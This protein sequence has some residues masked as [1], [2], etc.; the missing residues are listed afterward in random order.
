MKEFEIKVRCATKSINSLLHS[1]YYYVRNDRK[2][3]N[4]VVEFSHTTERCKCSPAWL[5]A[6]KMIEKQGTETKLILFMVMSQ[7][8]KVLFLFE[9]N[10]RLLMQIV[11][12]KEDSL[13]KSKSQPQ[14]YCGL[15]HLKVIIICIS[16][17][18]Y[19]FGTKFRNKDPA[20]KLILFMGTLQCFKIWNFLTKAIYTQLKQLL[21]YCYQMPATLS[22]WWISLN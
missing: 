16:I 10:S 2:R 20:L 17:P 11:R 9:L 13:G 15:L 21:S 14:F 22:A 1:S 8:N 4:P 3:R 7:R 6:R 12:I 5:T 18:D 19:E